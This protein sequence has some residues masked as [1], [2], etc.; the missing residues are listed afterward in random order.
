[1]PDSGR[2]VPWSEDGGAKDERSSFDKFVVDDFSEVI[3]NLQQQLGH[4]QV[5]RKVEPLASCQGLHCV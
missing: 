5:F 4:Q 1:M 3:D 2:V